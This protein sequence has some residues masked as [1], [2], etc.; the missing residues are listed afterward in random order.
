MR[1][2]VVFL[3]LLTGGLGCS[4][5]HE[6]PGQPAP[7]QLPPAAIAARK[8]GQAAAVKRL[9]SDGTTPTKQILFGDLHV[10]TTFSADAFM[11]SLPMLQGEG[12]HPPADACDFARFCSGL[13]FWSINDHAEAHLAAALAGDQGDHPA[14]QRRGRRSARI[15]TSSRSSAGSGRRSGRRPTSTTATRTSSSATP[16]T[17]RFRRAR[18]ARS[19]QQLIGAL[20]QRR[21]ALAAH[22][23]F[24]LLDFAESPALLRLRRRT[25]RSCATSARARRAWT[26]GTLPA[27]CHESRADARRSCSRSCR[28]GASTPSSSRTARRGASTRRR[29]RPSTSSSPAQARPG[30]S[31]RLF[32]VYSGHGNSEEYRDWKAIDWDAHGH[33]DLPAADQELRAVLLAAGEIIR[34]A[35]RQHL[36]RGV[37]APRGGQRA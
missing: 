30:A 35:L 25:R 7:A 13:D 33:A 19:S 11:R 24:P 28:S 10:H 18:S 27:D 14:V 29:A 1:R 4:G 32:E 22:L 37:R 6:G 5:Q 2:V 36:D 21:A 26:P 15:P 31:R 17:T 9:I 34:R 23:Q 12:A 8:D 20:R 16:T 3:V